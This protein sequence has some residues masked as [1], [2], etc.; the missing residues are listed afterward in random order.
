NTLDFV[1]LTLDEYD[2]ETCGDCFDLPV[3]FYDTISALPR[4]LR[5]CKFLESLTLKR[6]ASLEIGKSMRTSDKSL[7]TPN[8]PRSYGSTLQAGRVKDSRYLCLIYGLVTSRNM[9]R[10]LMCLELI[11]NAVNI[12]FVTF[13]DFFDSRQLKGNILSIFVIT[14]AAA[15]AAIV[16]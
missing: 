16:T 6:N 1:D 13:S 14:I 10:A 7:R 5:E 9:V 12:N 4:L 11:L 15:E 2:L 8:L 3:E